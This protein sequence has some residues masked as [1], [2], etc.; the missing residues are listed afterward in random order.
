MEL[1]G[2][3][4]VG[5]ILYW[6]MGFWVRVLVFVEL[7]YW[8]FLTFASAPGPLEGIEGIRPRW[9][10]RWLGLQ[11]AV[12]S[13]SEVVPSSLYSHSQR[14]CLPQPRGGGG[15]ATSRQDTRQDS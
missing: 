2:I 14:S 13:I 15:D 10:G 6:F 3:I 7:A 11:S 1:D 12:R 5:G 9:G 8:L 4:S